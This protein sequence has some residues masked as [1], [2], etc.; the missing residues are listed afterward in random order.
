MNMFH[1]KQFEIEH[2]MFRSS[3]L[4][5]RP[6][7]ITATHHVPRETFISAKIGKL[8]LFAHQGFFGWLL[9]F[10]AR[11]VQNPVNHNSVQF[12]LEIV[13]EFSGILRHPVDTDIDF[14][15]KDFWPQS[16]R[17]WWC[18][19]VYCALG[20]FDWGKEGIHQS[21]RWNWFP[22]S[23]SFLFWLRI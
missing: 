1:V 6:E 17:R 12:I 7:A 22:Q 14:S 8:L 19:W 15:A 10:I 5:M 13:F 4:S 11:K 3:G 23:T 18:Q 21:K 2:F 20:I 9:V 16:N